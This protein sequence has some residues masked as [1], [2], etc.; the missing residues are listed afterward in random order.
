MSR[1]RTTR[2]L[3]IDRVKGAQTDCLSMKGKLQDIL[4]TYQEDAPELTPEVAS[5]LQGVELMEDMINKLVERVR[6]A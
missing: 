6:T 4:G 5:V 1:K 2:Q 3:M